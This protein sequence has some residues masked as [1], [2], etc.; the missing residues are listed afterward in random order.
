MRVDGPRSILLCPL[1]PLPCECGT[2]PRSSSKI[3]K[4]RSSGMVVDDI[5]VLIVIL[6][7]DS[8]GLAT[9]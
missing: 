2:M 6:A 5:H 4:S 3:G 7:G 1:G 9:L 8:N